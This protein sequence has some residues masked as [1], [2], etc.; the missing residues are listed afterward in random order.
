M[1]DPAK[2]CIK[3]L[4]AIIYKL[5]KDKTPSKPDEVDEAFGDIAKVFQDIFKD[6]EKK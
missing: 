5:E 1:S 6:R 4:N 3:A 2:D